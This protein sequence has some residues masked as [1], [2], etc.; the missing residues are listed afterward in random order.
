[1]CVS[2]AHT[3]IMWN[4]AG[5]FASCPWK[6]YCRHY[7]VITF[8]RYIRAAVINDL[9]QRLHKVNVRFKSS[10]LRVYIVPIL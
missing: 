10:K 9:A 2:C 7:G 5:K 8:S 4:E 1:M 6:T 3:I